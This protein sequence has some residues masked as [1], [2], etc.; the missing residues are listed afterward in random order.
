MYV[1]AAVRPLKVG[2]RVVPLAIVGDAG[3]ETKAQT[4]DAT[5]PSESVAD[6]PEIVT[7][8]VG[9]VIARSEPA[10]ET[11]ATLAAINVVVARR[12]LSGYVR[13]HSGSQLATKGP[14]EPVPPG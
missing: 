12:R 14:G 2:V 7:E 11:G 3:P 6:A 1:P 5:V 13:H 9:S 10:F 4:R 8:L